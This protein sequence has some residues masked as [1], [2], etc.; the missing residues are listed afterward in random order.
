MWHIP[1]LVLQGDNKMINVK[2][3]GVASMLVAIGVVTSAFYIPIGAAKCFPVQSM[4]NII[5]GVFLGPAY[6]VEAAFATSTLRLLLGTGSMLAFPGSMIGALCC[7]LLYKYSQKLYLAYA[8]E[9]IGTGILGALAAY[10]IVTMLMSKQAALF[11]Y[12]FPFIISSLC[13]STIAII[14]VGVLKRIKILDQ[15]KSNLEL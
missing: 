3:L 2:K 8:G 6:A 4:I 15:L 1:F 10:P 13:G 12:V 5:A 9:V 14:L 11:A 7:G